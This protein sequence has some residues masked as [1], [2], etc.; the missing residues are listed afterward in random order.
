[1]HCLVPSFGVFRGS[2]IGSR[3]DR[4]VSVVPVPKI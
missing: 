2:L 4:V 1:M 3:I